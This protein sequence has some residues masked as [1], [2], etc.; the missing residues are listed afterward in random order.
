MVRAAVNGRLDPG[1]FTR[2]KPAAV[3]LAYS[4]SIKPA[5]LTHRLEDA[6]QR[7]PF[8][9]VRV[10]NRE[11]SKLEQV[12]KPGDLHVKLGLHLPP[13]VEKPVRLRNACVSP[14]RLDAETPV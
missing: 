11:F 6:A 13:P 2:L 10:Y 9:I 14:T 8:P 5:E 12:A 4:G 7:R 3:I 1:V